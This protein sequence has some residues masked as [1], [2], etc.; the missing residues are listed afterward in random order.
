[1]T[2]AASHLSVWRPTRADPYDFFTAEEVDRS[3]AYQRPLRWMRLVRVALSLAVVVGFLLAGAGSSIDDAAASQPWPVQLALV[4]VALEALLLVIDVPID[5]WVDFVHDRRWE[6]VDPDSIDVR[7]DQ[8][9]SFV[10]STVLGLALLVPVVRAD[11][12]HIVVVAHRLGARHRPRCAARIPVPGRDRARVQSLRAT[13]RRGARRSPRAGGRRVGRADSGCAGGRRES[14]IPARQR[15][16]ERARSD[17]AGGALR[18]DPRAPAR[19]HR[20]GGRARVRPLAASSS[21]PADLR[22]SR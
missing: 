10:L 22:F 3:R 21:A 12:R 6:S 11:P 1:M 16:R 17:P 14:E 15:V 19:A 9:K 7:A 18:H 4:F 2:A 13:R 8:V 5:I 20:R